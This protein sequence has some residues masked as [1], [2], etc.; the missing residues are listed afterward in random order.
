MVRKCWLAFVVGAACAFAAEAPR[1]VMGRLIR[2]KGAPHLS[3]TLRHP[4]CDVTRNVPVAQAA[5]W[6][7]LRPQLAAEGIHVLESGELTPAIEKRWLIAST[8]PPGAVQ[9]ALYLRTA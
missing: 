3:L 5:G 9:P 7:S 8:E 4:T 2:L 6:G 1:K